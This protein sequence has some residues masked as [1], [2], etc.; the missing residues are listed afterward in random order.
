MNIFSKITD[1]IIIIISE[2]YKEI[3][4]MSDPNLILLE[5]GEELT[6]NS[7]RNYLNKENSK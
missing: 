6:T 3:K 7:N 2:K 5:Q 4:K 1:Q